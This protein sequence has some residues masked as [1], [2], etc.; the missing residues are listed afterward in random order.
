MS[1]VSLFY[2]AGAGMLRAP[3]HPLRRAGEVWWEIEAGA[4]DEPAQFAEVLQ[5]LA[6]PGLVTEALALAAPSLALMVNR[7]ATGTT[8]VGLAQLRRGVRALSG[9]RLRMAQRATPFGLMAGIAPV[10]FTDEPGEAKVRWGD[11]HRRGVRPDREWLTGL[12]AVWEQRPEVLRRLRVVRNDL[13]FVRGDR[14][15]VPYVPDTG[16]ARAGN[17]MVQEVSVRHTQA[18]ATVL[19]AARMPVTGGVLARRLCELFPTASL[20][21]VEAM[22]AQLVTK[23]ILL[24]EARP[25][26]EATDPLGYVLEVFEGVPWEE[27][28]ELEQLREIRGLLDDY[29]RCPVGAGGE[30]LGAACRRMREVHEGEHLVQVDLALD[31]E[32]RLPREVAEE[33][34]RAAGLLWRLAPV[35]PGQAY[36]RQYHDDFLARYGTDRLVPVKELLD[37]GIGLGA[38]AG[39]RRP[40]SRRSLRVESDQ[41]TARDQVLAGLAQQALLAGDAEVVLDD[42][43]PVVTALARERGT[44][45]DSLDLRAH[46]L[47]HSLES[48]TAGRFRLILDGHSA[49]AGAM[50]GRFTYLLP[51]DAQ[52][53]VHDLARGVEAREP[54]ALCAQV[55]VQTSQSRSANV[56]QVP[57]WLGH[58]LPVARFSERGDPAVLNLDRLAIGADHDRLFVVDIETGRRVRPVVFH[59]LNR[60]WQVPN[61]A[62]FLHDL[63]GSG[64]HPWRPWNWGAAAALPYLPRVRYGRAVLALARWRPT[65]ALRDQSLSR[66]LWHERV[67]QWRETWRVPRHVRVGQDDR[68]VELDLDESVHLDLLRH[69]LGRNPSA[70]VWEVPTRTGYHDGWLAGSEGTHRGEIVFPLLAQ[71]FRAADTSAAPL[72]VESSGPLRGAEQTEPVRLRPVGGEHLPGGEWLYT[73]VYCAR[74]RQDEV[75]TV[76][77]PRLLATLPDGVD[78]WFFLRYSDGSEHLRLRWHAPAAVLAGEL[79]PQVHAFVAEL[80]DCGLTRRVVIDTYDPEVERYGGPQAMAAAEKVFHADSV[81]VLETLRLLRAGRITTAPPLLA[82]TSYMALARAFF[83]ARD[84]L[85]GPAADRDAGAR[86]LLERLSKNQQAHRHFRQMRREALAL[87]R[88]YDDHAPLLDTIDSEVLRTVWSQRNEAV[89]AYGHTLR[90]LGT[91]SWTSPA[92]V[93]ASLLHMHHNRLIGSDGDAEQTS[94]AIAR[95]AVAAHHDRRGHAR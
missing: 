1:G 61:A 77:L 93:L 74:E 17:A 87:I 31:V 55:S 51:D 80:R 4:P 67:A 57:Q 65:E 12:V 82:A 52:A 85:L 68:I 54:D 83:T 50:L 21:T 8:G 94:Y 43:H 42:S 59:M 26:L 95:G 78:R 39:Y 60:E 79:L 58:L 40:V 14:L 75:L 41:D 49:Q 23:E 2:C 10:G 15:V 91:R 88:P 20:G 30:T 56:A 72:A 46:V 16:V 66:E 92:S 25:P 37:P 44:P 89:L 7:V 27:L 33:A 35:P 5:R 64:V 69:E 86:W 29:A 32:A 76:H 6:E 3:A 84:P 53:V 47:A 45:P 90:A 70:I 9:Y 62:R 71:Q 22:L 34:A 24:T 28:P 18:V 73:S 19:D 63:A 38:P 36:L 48:L 81:T 11:S 13:T